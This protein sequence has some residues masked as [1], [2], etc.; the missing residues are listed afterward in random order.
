MPEEGSS[1]PPASGRLVLRMPA[2]L[3]NELRRMAIQENVSINHLICASLAGAIRWRAPDL[4]MRAL[5]QEAR[6][7]MIWEGWASMFR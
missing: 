4:D 6:E 3:H 2:T 5:S 1:N 7:R